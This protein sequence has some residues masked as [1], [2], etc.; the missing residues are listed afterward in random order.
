MWAIWD[1]QLEAIW[2]AAPDDRP[3]LI[4]GVQ[5][6]TAPMKEMGLLSGGVEDESAVKRFLE[7]IRSADVVPGLPPIPVYEDDED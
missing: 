7:A 2:N 6:M 1:D 4:Y 5:R 3:A